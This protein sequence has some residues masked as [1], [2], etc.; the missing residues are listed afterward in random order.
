MNRRVTG[1]FSHDFECHYQRKIG[2]APC[3]GQREP[4]GYPA[5]V[6]RRPE[7]AL[8]DPWRYVEHQVAAVQAPYV[9]LEMLN[10]LGWPSHGDCESHPFGYKY[11]YRDSCLAYHNLIV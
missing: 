2:R 6:P 4:H 9:S 10:F 1:R 3:D 5:I 8:K 7:G 11:K